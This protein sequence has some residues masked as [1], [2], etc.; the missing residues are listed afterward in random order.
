MGSIYEDRV[1][2]DVAIAAGTLV[3]RVV[4]IP[5]CCPTFNREVVTSTGAQVC[6]CF[7]SLQVVIRLVQNTNGT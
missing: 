4:D 6:A 7:L 5:A 1:E 3:V 2:S